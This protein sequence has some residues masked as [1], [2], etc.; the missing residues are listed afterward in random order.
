[1]LKVLYALLL[2][3]HVS[4]FGLGFKSSMRNVDGNCREEERKALINFKQAMTSTHI[5]I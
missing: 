4:E 1:M 2:L 5:F 3:L